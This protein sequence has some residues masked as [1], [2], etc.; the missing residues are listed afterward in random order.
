MTEHARGKLQPHPSH[1]AKPAGHL[2]FYKKHAISPVRYKVE[3]HA[4]MTE[5]LFRQLRVLP[6]CFR[7]RAVLEVAAGSGQTAQYVES[8]D[9]SLQVIVEPNPVGMAHIERLNLAAWHY[10]CTLEDF[11]YPDKFD[12]VICQNWLGVNERHLLKKLASFVAPGG[13]LL[14]TCM[15]TTGMLPNALRREIAE[16]LLVPGAPFEE[17]VSILTRAFGPHLAT[18]KD[19]TRT[20]EDW[21]R[22][23]MLNPAWHGIGLTLRMLIKEIGADFDILGTSPDFVEDWRWFKSLTGKH[24]YNELALTEIQRKDRWFLDYRVFNE[25][26]LSDSMVALREGYR[27]LEQESFTVDDVA[28]MKDFKSL[29]GRETIHVSFSKN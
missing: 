16:R 23:N 28:A 7:G 9:P 2:E 17:Q 19:M 11:R 25:P 26:A 27:L 13:I 22:D 29:F 18:M 15:S 20:P 1:A 10:S 8:L 21:V 4:A 5:S 24:L 12:I 6:Q 14:T 3:G